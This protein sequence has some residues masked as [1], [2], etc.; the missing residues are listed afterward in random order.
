MAIYLAN[1]W[2]CQT[3]VNVC[4]LNELNDQTKF[5]HL[6]NFFCLQESNLLTNRILKECCLFYLQFGNS[7][8]ANVTNKQTIVTILV[9]VGQ[10]DTRRD[11]IDIGIVVTVGQQPLFCWPICDRFTCRSFSAFVSFGSPD[12]F[13]S[14]IITAATIP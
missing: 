4:Y 6:F 1:E 2:L 8:D 7:I 5:K 12:S 10:C 11:G 9:Q 3:N 13:F 14:Q